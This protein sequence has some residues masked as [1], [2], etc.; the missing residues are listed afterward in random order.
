MPAKPKIASS[1]S[2]SINKYG[3]TNHRNEM[4]EAPARLEV[5]KRFKTAGFS[6]NGSCC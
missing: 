6:V 5:E 2:R 4:R 3:R 1:M